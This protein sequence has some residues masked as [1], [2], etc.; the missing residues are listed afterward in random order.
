[1]KFGVLIL[2]LTIVAAAQKPA[3]A[4]SSGPAKTPP[5]AANPQDVN[6]QKARTLINQAIQAL[7]GQAYLNVQDMRQEGRA[8]TFY[9]GEANGVGTIFWRFWKWPNKDRVELTKQRDVIYIENGDK[10]YETTFKGTCYQNPVD[11]A[12]YMRQR[13]FSLDY[14]LRTWVPQPDIALFYEGQTVA[15]NREAET[16]TIMNSKNQAV[17]LYLDQQTHLPIKKTYV[18]RDQDR[19][20]NEEAEIYGNYHLVQG[21]NTPFD[22]VRQRNGEMTRQ[23]FITNVSYNV[24]IPDSTFEAKATDRPDCKNS[25]P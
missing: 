14:V 4:P 18:W 16:V 19:Y 11:L 10:G 13:E 9:H 3:L 24:N 23:R 8:Y 21:I 22:T 2:L 20:R 6:A 25:L 15:D 17:T 12:E 7:G 1:M 5:A